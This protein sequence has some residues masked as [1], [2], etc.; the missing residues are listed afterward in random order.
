MVILTWKAIQLFPSGDFDTGMVREAEILDGRLK[1]WRSTLP[2]SL[3]Y[4]ADMP[5]P[6]YEVQ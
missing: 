4:A 3:R 6:L 1:H 5:P 2:P